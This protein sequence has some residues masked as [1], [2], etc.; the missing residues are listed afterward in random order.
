MQDPVGGLHRLYSCDLRR[1][2]ARRFGADHDGV[3][4]AIQ[5][6]FLRFTQLPAHETVANPRAL[7]LVMARNLLLDRLRRAAAAQ[8]RLKQDHEASELPNVEERTPEN[9]LLEKERLVRLNQAILDLPEH[10][11]RL[12]T[13]SRIEGL[14]YAEIS[15]LTGRSPADISRQIARAVAALQARMAR[16]FGGRT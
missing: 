7:L 3:E 13:L 14:S 8:R 11:R 5:A 10:Q 9:V 1:V 12:L 16:D 2:L 6:A 15:K 4:D